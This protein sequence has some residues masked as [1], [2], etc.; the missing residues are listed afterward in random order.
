MQSE[1]RSGYFWFNPWNWLFGIVCMTGRDSWW[2]SGTPKKRLSSN[3]DSILGMRNNK[4]GLDQSIKGEGVRLAQLSFRSSIIPALCLSSLSWIN[5]QFCFSYSS[6]SF[7][8]LA[9]SGFGKAPG[10]NNDQPF[11]LEEQIPHKQCPH[12]PKGHVDGR[13]TWKLTNFNQIF[14]P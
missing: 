4:E 1:L 9:P 3:C 6:K 8:R 11:S 13:T 14:A 7:W 12:R 10:K 5:N 2:I